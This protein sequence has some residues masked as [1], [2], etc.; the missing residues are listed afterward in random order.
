M[1]LQFAGFFGEWLG[2]CCR[3]PEIERRQA[4]VNPTAVV[5]A[6]AALLERRA[7]AGGISK[8]CKNTGRLYESWK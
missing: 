7:V 3:L 5:A 2:G 8:M 4:P 1:G 6:P